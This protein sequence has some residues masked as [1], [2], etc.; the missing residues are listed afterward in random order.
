MKGLTWIDFFNFPQK[1]KE[2]AQD[3]RFKYKDIII[4]GPLNPEF[5]DYFFLMTLHM[6]IITLDRVYRATKVNK[7]TQSSL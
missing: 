4:H 5:A 1:K 7:N 2:F 3:C 6:F